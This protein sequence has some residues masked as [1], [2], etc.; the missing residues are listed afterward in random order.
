MSKEFKLILRE[1]SDDLGEP[2]RHCV[3][4]ITEDAAVGDFRYSVCDLSECPE[5]ATICRDLFS[6]W[7]YI[8]ALMLGMKIAKAGYD[9]ITFKT[10]NSRAVISWRKHMSKKVKS[11]T[12]TPY[13]YYNSFGN[14]VSEGV[15]A[16]SDLAD[17]GGFD[18]TTYGI[19][20]GHLDILTSKD[21]IEAV[22][23]G[24]ALAKEGI[25]EIVVSPEKKVYIDE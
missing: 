24:M 2:I 1:A 22:Q 3:S 25:D 23:Y 6:G 20:N 17:Y 4:N 10:K 11:I 18:V 7:E 13:K 21:Y 9:T 19:T 5:D 12:M 15:E 8:D 14:I 16:T